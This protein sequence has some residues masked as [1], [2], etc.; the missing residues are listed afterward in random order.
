MGEDGTAAW[1]VTRVAP[2]PSRSVP[3]S[4][5]HIWGLSGPATGSVSAA[6][7]RSSQGPALAVST[8]WPSGAVT[9]APRLKRCSPPGVGGSAEGAGQAPHGRALAQ[10][11]GSDPFRCAPHLQTPHAPLR[12]RR[13][14]ADAPS[15]RPPTR[16]AVPRCCGNEPFLRRSAGKGGPQLMPIQPRPTT[17]MNKGA[18]ESSRC[19]CRGRRGGNLARPRCVLS[20]S[21]LPRAG[22]AGKGLTD[23]HLGT[24]AGED[25]GWQLS[26]AASVKT[27]PCE[28]LL[29]EAQRPPSRP[30]VRSLFL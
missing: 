17:S 25:P 18:R 8:W 20:P 13:H 27:R 30:R 12:R 6:R 26:P 3:P 22:G 2:R 29:R 5:W 14:P 10:L 4:P 9:P 21:P 16:G 11:L 19:V 7:P 24:G 15:P 23:P 28:V 1:T